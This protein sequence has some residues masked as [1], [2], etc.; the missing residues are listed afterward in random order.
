MSKSFEP[1]WAIQPPQYPNSYIR[2]KKKASN[3]SSSLRALSNPF[4]I[5]IILRLAS[6]ISWSVHLNTRRYLRFPRP[7]PRLHQL[8]VS[9]E[10]HAHYA[11]RCIIS[12][13]LYVLCFHVMFSL[14]LWFCSHSSEEWSGCR[15][16]GG[17]FKHDEVGCSPLWSEIELVACKTLLLYR[18]SDNL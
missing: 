1:R 10:H 14:A 9:Q 12:A 8:C 5:S 18:E 3:I 15:R 7:S 2:F 11:K 4:P 13:L 16:N 6:W 17:S